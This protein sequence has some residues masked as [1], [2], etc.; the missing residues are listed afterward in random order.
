MTFVQQQKVAL[1][2]EIKAVLDSWVRYEKQVKEGERVKLT[3][4]VIEKVLADLKDE[5]IQ[6]EVILGAVTEIERKLSP[7]SS[8]LLLLLILVSRTCQAQGYLDVPRS[9]YPNR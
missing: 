3:N 5:K 8:I 2:S 9:S 7:S 4:H 6:K 1:A